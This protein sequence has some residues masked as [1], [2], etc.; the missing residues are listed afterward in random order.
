M[1]RESLRL[2]APG[3]FWYEQGTTFSSNEEIAS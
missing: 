3:G 2:K 1:G